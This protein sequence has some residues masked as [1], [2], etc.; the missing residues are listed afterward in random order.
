MHAHILAHFIDEEGLTK[1]FLLIT[2]EWDSKSLKV[3]HFFE[4]EYI[5]LTDDAVR[6]SVDKVHVGPAP[7]PWRDHW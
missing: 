4:I 6:R 2:I 5:R 7:Y 3:N 1:N